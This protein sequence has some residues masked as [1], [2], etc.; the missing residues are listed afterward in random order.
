MLWNIFNIPFWKLC[1]IFTHMHWYAWEMWRSCVIFWSIMGS[2]QLFCIVNIVHAA[3]KWLCW[4]SARSVTWFTHS[5]TGCDIQYIISNQWLI[6]LVRHMAGYRFDTRLWCWRKERKEENVQQNS[7]CLS[8]HLCVFDHW[9]PCHRYIHLYACTMA[10][11][12]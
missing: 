5:G 8:A 1:R 10:W 3:C 2:T 4:N 11:R 6:Y 12:C 7:C 9:T